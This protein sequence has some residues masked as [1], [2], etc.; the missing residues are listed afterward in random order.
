MRS[1]Y[2]ERV[3]E[4][5]N[6]GGISAVRKSFDGK[7]AVNDEHWFSEMAQALLKPKPGTALHYIT[8]YD[9]RLCQRY[10]AGSVKPS[11]YFLRR[12]LRSKQGAT[13]AAIALDGAPWWRELQR[14]AEIGRAVVEITKRN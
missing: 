5:T 10:A 9:E 12:L 3:A 13:F 14:M 7:S 4:A 11:A 1:V 6:G 8:G 2:E